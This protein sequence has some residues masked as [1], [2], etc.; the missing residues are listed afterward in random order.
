VNGRLTLDPANLRPHIAGAALM[1]D[2]QVDTLY[3]YPVIGSISSHL[4]VNPIDFIAVDHA[5]DRAAHC[6]ALT[7][8][9]GSILTDHHLN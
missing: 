8:G 5:V 4:P 7:P 6:S 9:S 3:D 2:D 1:L